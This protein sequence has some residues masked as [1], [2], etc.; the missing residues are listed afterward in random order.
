M[1]L[2]DHRVRVPKQTPSRGGSIQPRR[3]KFTGK[4]RE[5]DQ[6]LH[7]EKY[8]N[9]LYIRIVKGLPE[10]EEQSF[11]NRPKAVTLLKPMTNQPLGKPPLATN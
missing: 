8:S 6:E 4:V 2:D 9:T 1:I 5:N 10:V 3:T 11:M 7:V